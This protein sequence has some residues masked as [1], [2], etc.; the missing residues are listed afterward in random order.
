[1]GS[2]HKNL[3]EPSQLVQ[4]RRIDPTVEPWAW[5]SKSFCTW[6]DDLQLVT[7]QFG[8]PKHTLL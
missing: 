8:D 1:M 6:T 2:H 7:P 5:A 4:S 3:N